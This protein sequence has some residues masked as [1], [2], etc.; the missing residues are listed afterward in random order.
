MH[1][2]WNIHIVDEFKQ[3]QSHTKGSLGHPNSNWS[4]TLPPLSWLKSKLYCKQLA[5]HDQFP[6]TASHFCWVR[7]IMHAM[8]NPKKV[9]GQILIAY[10]ICVEIESSIRYSCVLGIWRHAS[11]II[12][13]PLL[14]SQYHIQ[15]HGCH[16]NSYSPCIPTICLTHIHSHQI[17]PHVLRLC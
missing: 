16:S 9:K 2:S 10:P 1:Q 7:E 13:T 12:P 5:K 15:R 3:G 11:L 4:P 6:L 17:F 14:Y 8:C